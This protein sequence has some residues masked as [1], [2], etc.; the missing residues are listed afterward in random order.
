MKEPNVQKRELLLRLSELYDNLEELDSVL[1]ISI[2]EYKRTIQE[3]HLK[4]LSVCEE[5]LLAM[6]TKFDMVEIMEQ[7]RS[8]VKGSGGILELGY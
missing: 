2:T 7:K 6:E 3:E 1:H 8:G 4:T 5:R